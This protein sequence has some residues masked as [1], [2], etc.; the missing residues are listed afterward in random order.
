MTKMALLTATLRRTLREV[1]RFYDER[2]VG[3]VG[4]LGFRRSS[5]LKKLLPPLES[6]ISEGLLR[7]GKSLFLDMG[8]G[9]GRVNVLLS[10]LVRLSAGMELDEWT[11]D[12]YQQL[13]T[14]LIGKLKRRCLPVPPDNIRLFNGDALDEDLYRVLEE[15][16]GV[17]FGDFDIFYTYLTMHD[18]FAEIIARKARKGAIFMVYGLN[19]ILPKYQGLRLLTSSGSLNGILAIYQKP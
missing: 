4:C 13:R 6:L 11:L 8:C 7:P 18:E 16:T 14:A 5:D 3:D 12:D 10:Y 9:D 15:E 19:S 2:K 1:A 17:P